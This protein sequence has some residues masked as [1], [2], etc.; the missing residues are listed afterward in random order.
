MGP[1]F[2]GRGSFFGDY[3]LFL[4]SD[5]SWFARGGPFYDNE[6]TGLFAF[7]RIHGG[8]VDQTFRVVLTP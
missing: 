7:M 4:S 5:G 3:S 2:G 1:F 8:S 6:N